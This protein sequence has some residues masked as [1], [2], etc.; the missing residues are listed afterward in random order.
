VSPAVTQALSSPLRIGG[1]PMRVYASAFKD[2]PRNA[3]IPIVVELDV[4][5]FTF[6]QQNDTYNDKV[7][8]AYAATGTNGKVYTARRT[9]N[10]ALKPETYERMKAGGLSV[11]MQASLP[12]GRYQLHVAAGDTSGKV[13]H[14][15][16]NLEVPDF[17]NAS[18]SLSGIALTSQTAGQVISRLA[19]SKDWLKDFLP[20]PV[21]AMRDFPVGDILTVF[22]EVYENVHGATHLVDIKTELRN[23]SS[24]AIRNVGGPVSSSELERK[25]GGY[26]FTASLSLND[27]KPGRY[28]I[29]VEAQSRA[30]SQPMVSRDVEIRVR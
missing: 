30:G 3:V 8:V 11:I 13:G 22:G 1:V 16:Y 20:G 17:S 12:P 9:V 25:S 18:L 26:G 21:T 10:V 2:T 29:H 23:E 14:V 7:D 5:N 4:S 15:I 24:Q 27:V 19:A 28:V 6:G